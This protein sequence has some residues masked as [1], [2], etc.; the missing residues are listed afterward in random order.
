[1]DTTQNTAPQETM[2]WAPLPD[3]EPEAAPKR[4]REKPRPSIKKILPKFPK[5]DHRHSGKVATGIDN[6]SIGR[7]APKS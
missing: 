5:K 3:P 1:M 4:K 6:A 7:K 2:Q